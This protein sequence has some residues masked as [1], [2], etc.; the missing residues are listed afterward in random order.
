MKPNQLKCA[1]L[2]R[3]FVQLLSSIPQCSANIVVIGNGIGVNEHFARHEMLLL[4]LAYEM[5]DVDALILTHGNEIQVCLNEF[6]NRADEFRES[7]LCQTYM[8]IG[9]VFDPR[10]AVAS[11]E[12]VACTA[13]IRK[14]PDA[15]LHALEI[16]TGIRYR[17]T[18]TL[19][20]FTFEIGKHGSEYPG[21]LNIGE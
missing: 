6:A 11:G 7:E 8:P 13:G 2:F 15:V 18:P 14:N 19:K 12:Y 17:L 9:V 4:N 10:A 3:C 20:R 5:R 1:W 16:Q 21:E